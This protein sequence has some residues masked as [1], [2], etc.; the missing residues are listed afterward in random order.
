M[1][2]SNSIHNSASGGVRNRPK[3]YNL[4]NEIKTT[5]VHPGK[6]RNILTEDRNMPKEI[7]QDDAAALSS[8][9]KTSDE[10]RPFMCDQSFEQL[11]NTNLS[12]K[13]KAN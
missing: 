4:S 10:P 1:E 12:P 2:K 7:E 6:T 3:F 9:M 11:R 5:P 13:L 8:K